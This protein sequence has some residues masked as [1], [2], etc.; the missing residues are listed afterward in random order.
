M[1]TG[2]GPRVGGRNAAGLDLRE[3]G[4]LGRSFV[5]TPTGPIGY[6]DLWYRGRRRRDR[7]YGRVVHRC[8]IA[9]QGYSSARCS[10]IGTCWCTRLDRKLAT[11]GAWIPATGDRGTSVV[12]CW[13]RRRRPGGRTRW[14]KRERD[15][16][17]DKC[18]SGN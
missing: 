2:A 6:R 4:W 13:W 17:Y 9:E 12:T 15:D 16:P 10:V 5:A 1:V 14:E 3:I 7:H 8:L 11:D 18:S